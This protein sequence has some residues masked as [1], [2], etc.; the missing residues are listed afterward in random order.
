MNRLLA[1]LSGALLVFVVLSPVADAQRRGG[2]GKGRGA[3]ANTVPTQSGQRN[4]TYTVN[5][6]S[7]LSSQELLRMWE[8]E[9]LARDV[10]V[11]LAK[12]SN[13]FVFE[14]ISRAE[15]Q[16]MQALEG[17][18][19]GTGVT[20]PN[21]VAGVFTFADY[22]QLYTTLVSSGSRSPVDALRVGAK[23]E[24]MDIADLKV[25]IAATNVPQL[26]RVLESLKRGSE[27]HL[28]AFASQLARHGASYQAEF[29]T[30]VEF[31]QIANSTG[32]GRGQQAGRGMGGDG[33]GRG[34]GRRGGGNGN[35]K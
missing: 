23:I 15:T 24:E 14:N 30:Q 2:S 22:Q 28:R 8:E 31:D 19:R 18:L 21:D 12:T 17:L 20:P 6:T 5:T 27:N 1:T 29:L 11:Q 25:L 9:K 33:Q 13:L 34:M 35:G 7:S 26:R 10:Y 32:T 3:A 4:R 16:H